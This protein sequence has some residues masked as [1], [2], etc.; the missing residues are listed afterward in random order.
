MKTL[1]L[2]A[3]AVLCF[4]ATEPRVS[5]KALAGVE[6][7]M[8]DKFRGVSA[9]PY[10]LIGPARGTYMDG[11]GAV[12][13]VQVQMV[14]ITPPNPFRPA[15]TPAELAALRDHKL[16]KLPLMKEMMRG[17]MADA[18][19]T[20]DAMPGNEKISME[21]ILWRF[22]WEDSH[23]LPQRVQMT[24]E[25]S[26]LIEAAANHADLASVITEQDQ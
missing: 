11:Y 18:C 10:D 16:K 3:V 8:N 6:G 26:R 17:L 4:G 23:G 9:D 15:Y 20:L 2:L 13:T 21:A 5:L 7:A 14:Y 19:N 25:K 1:V 24:A 22:N 12:F